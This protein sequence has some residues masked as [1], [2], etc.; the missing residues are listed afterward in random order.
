MIGEVV[1]AVIAF[2]LFPKNECFI[3][4]LPSLLRNKTSTSLLSKRQ[5]IGEKCE[6]QRCIKRQREI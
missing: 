1:K 6:Q 2:Y 5:L 3:E 4:T